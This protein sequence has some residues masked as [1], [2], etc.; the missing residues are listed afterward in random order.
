[1]DTSQAAGTND[2]HEHIQR[3]KE[4][5]WERKPILAKIIEKVGSKSLLEYVRGYL[6]VAMHP[7]MMQRK[8][9]FIETYS[10]EVREMFP[11]DISAKAIRQVHTSFLFS[12][13]DHHGPL[14]AFDMFNAHVVLAL[15]ALQYPSDDTPEAILLLSCANV[16]LNNV[17]FPRGI[18]FSTSSHNGIEA[19]KLSLLP[20]KHQ[21][22]ALYGLSAYKNA[23]VLRMR[24]HLR[25]LVS[26]GS[27]SRHVEEKLERIV[28]TIIADPAIVQR[29]TYSA[30]A[31]MINGKIWDLVFEGKMHAPA[32]ISVSIE[33]LVTRLL[34]DHHL[35]KDTVMSRF[36]FHPEYERHVLQKFDGIYGAF[37]QADRSGTYMFWGLNKNM[38]RLQMEKVGQNL[39]SFDGTV[40]IPWNPASIAKALQ[41]RTII[42]SMLLA[43]C[44]LAFYYGAK[45][46][47]GYSQVNYLTFMK[48]AFMDMM[49]ELGETEVAESCLPVST[50]H[51]SG[52]TCAYISDEKQRIA[53]AQFLDLHLHSDEQMWGR[54]KHYSQQCTLAQSV[55]PILPEIYRYSYE[56]EEREEALLRITPDDL[57]AFAH[58]KPCLCIR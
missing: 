18:L 23:D 34:L 27:I 15:S 40:T 57:I 13:N 2:L 45:C 16:S 5:V 37:S 9:E 38:R 8:A 35:G 21:M 6:T 44:T 42:P 11:D 12:T 50:K 29:K 55:A 22:S 26:N 47:G 52:F 14:N 51:W 19:Q 1:M 31:S 17:S 43:Y 58:L 41:D 20:S 3:L 24:N 53:P 56:A 39:V 10:K 48:F 7:L 30:Q 25:E 54:L 28:Q 49:K 32:L 33:R 36:L 46:L 4:R